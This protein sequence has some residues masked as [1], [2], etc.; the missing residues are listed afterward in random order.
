MYRQWVLGLKYEEFLFLVHKFCNI[1]RS[2]IKNVVVIGVNNIQTV[3]YNDAHTVY[4]N[5]QS[6]MGMNLT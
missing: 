6:V 4:P 1:N 2:S 5:S 3:S